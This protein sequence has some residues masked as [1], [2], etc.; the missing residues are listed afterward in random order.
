AG[1]PRAEGWRMGIEDDGGFDGREAVPGLATPGPPACN[2]VV[3]IRDGGLAT[4]SVKVRAWSRGTARLHH[5]IVPGTG[6]PADSCWRTV[7]VAAAT[8]VDAN[9]AS[10]AAILRGERAARW[11]DELHLPARLV[12][13]D[14]TTVLTRRWAARATGPTRATS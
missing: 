8:C 9:T 3:I 10:T 7:S 13:R 12:R 14:R 1:A 6:L 2:A 11:L 5:I 4:S